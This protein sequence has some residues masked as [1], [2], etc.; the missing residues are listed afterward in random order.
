M[1]EKKDAAPSFSSTV[2]SNA[3]GS[4][5]AAAVIAIVVAFI[6]G[7]KYSPQL[8]VMLLAGGPFLL[9]VITAGMVAPYVGRFA[10]HVMLRG[11][12]MLEGS[13]K[14]IAVNLIVAGFAWLSSVGLIF[15]LLIQSAVPLLEWAQTWVDN[16]PT[17]P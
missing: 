16:H 14:T 1:A 10:Q 2:V 8:R 4:L 3:L 17:F 11:D 15:L 12:T 6:G 5:V 7:D 13:L 9:L